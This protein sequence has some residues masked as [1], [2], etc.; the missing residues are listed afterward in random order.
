MCLKKLLAN[1][2]RHDETVFLS[3][4]RR[5]VCVAVPFC[6]CGFGGCPLGVPIGAALVGPCNHNSS[7]NLKRHLGCAGLFKAAQA[8]LRLRGLNLRLRRLN[9]RLR[10]LNLRLRRVN[11]RLRRLNL[12]LGRLNLRW[13]WIRAR[14]RRPAQ[15]TLPGRCPSSPPAHRIAG[16]GLAMG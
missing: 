2:S 14:F 11:L 1:R 16:R 4:P 10:R 7:T 6:M 13:W 5:N 3:R 15:G 12:R 9:L 8:Y